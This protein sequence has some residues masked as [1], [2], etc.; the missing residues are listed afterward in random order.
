MKIHR[1]EIIPVN[2]PLIEPFEISLETVTEANNVFVKIYTEDLVGIGESSPFKSILGES[3]SSQ[4]VIAQQLANVWINQPIQDIENCINLLDQVIAGN[5]GIK[6]AFDMALY[7]LNAQ[8]QGLPLYKFFGAEVKKPLETDMTIGM[9]STEEMVSSALKIKDQGFG[10]IKVKVGKNPTLDIERIASIRHAIGESVKLRIDA[11]QGW[12]LDQ[13]KIVLPKMSAFSVEH[14]EE[15]IAHWNL[16]GQQEIVQSSS[17]PIMADESI[18]D[19]HDARRLIDFDA[20]DAFNIK[21]AKSGGLY[22]AQKIIQIAQEHQMPCQVGCFSETRLGITALAHFSIAYNQIVYYDMDSP[23]MLV[24]DPILGGITYK[25]GKDV[26]IPGDQPGLG[27]A[28]DLSYID[29]NHI[30]SIS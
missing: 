24:D 27:V 9:Q 21:L 11:N 16:K 12:T 7:D 10:A 6:S 19:H 30:I 8:A 26:L 2:I 28:L 22:K 13:A 18:F 3:Q 5:H 25:N 17:I 15:P 14:C 4:I 1:V 20:C 23:L 29:Q